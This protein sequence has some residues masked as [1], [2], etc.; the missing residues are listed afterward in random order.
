MIDIHSHVIPTVDDGSR[1]VDETFKMIKEAHRAGFNGII[2]TSHYFEGYY[3]AKACQRQEYVDAFNKEIHKEWHN[4]K[5]YL[6]NEIYLTNKFA[7]LINQGKAV[8]LANSK[9]VLFEFSLN[10]KPLDAI[11]LVDQIF[12]QGFIPILAHPERYKFLQRDQDL[13]YEFAEEGVL[14][15]CNYGSLI[16]QYGRKAELLA[17]KLL[18]NDMVTF[19]GTDAHRQDTIYTKILECTNVMH[20]L[21]DGQKFKQITETN[22]KKI[23]DNQDIVP[24]TVRRLDFTYSERK[25]LEE[26]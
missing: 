17:R 13:L 2:C 7:D 10:V 15:Q 16:G 25:L 26:T 19:M 3:E 12:D 23:I 5:L 24:P 4:F 9:Y 21:I 22:P 20:N 6:G 14:L 1:S 18:E 11:E 8:P